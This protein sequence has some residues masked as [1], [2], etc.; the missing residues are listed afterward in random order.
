MNDHIQCVLGRNAVVPASFSNK[1][2][3]IWL[4]LEKKNVWN[5]IPV[6]RRICIRVKER[7]DEKVDHLKIVYFFIFLFNASKL[8]NWRYYNDDGLSRLLHIAVYYY[9]II[10]CIFL[11]VNPARSLKINLPC[12]GDME[13]IEGKK[14]VRFGL[15]MALVRLFNRSI[16]IT[17]YI[18]LAHSNS[19]TLALWRL[20]IRHLWEFVEFKD[21]IL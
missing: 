20:Q 11:F 16:S 15:S 14:Y 8:F 19:T 2:I 10:S 12:G 18:K 1:V 4:A 13:A 21:N 17:V 6:F 7:H 9:I 5:G 3:D